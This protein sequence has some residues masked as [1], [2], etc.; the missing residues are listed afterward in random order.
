MSVE[1]LLS[2]T[3]LL[4]AAGARGGHLAVVLLPFSSVVALAGGNYH[5]TAGAYTR[6]R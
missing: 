5:R 1:C 4:R 2:V 3:P 6:S